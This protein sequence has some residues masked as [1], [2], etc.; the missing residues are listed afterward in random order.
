MSS[1]KHVHFDSEFITLLVRPP[2]QIEL[3]ALY[4]FDHHTSN[5]V[6]CFQLLSP[7]SAVVWLCPIG[8]TLA[9]TLLRLFHCYRG[10]IYATQRDQM[11]CDIV[12]EVPSAFHTSYKWLREM[13]QTRHPIEYL[14]PL[15]IPEP[16][17]IKFRQ[18]ITDR[19][20]FEYQRSG[21]G[22]NTKL[23]V[24]Y[25]KSELVSFGIDHKAIL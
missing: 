17:K 23:T 16:A 12:V 4:D 20:H 2:N 24:L 6:T 14:K 18:N 10:H 8:K 11:L 19:R 15:Q 5:C 3:Q 9:R 21:A 7:P 1:T 25:T 22:E 13:W